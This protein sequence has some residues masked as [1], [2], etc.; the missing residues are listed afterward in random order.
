MLIFN[1]YQSAY[2]ANAVISLN[3][4]LGGD[5]TVKWAEIQQRE[6]GKHMIPKPDIEFMDNVPNGYV[7]EK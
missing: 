5:I 7:E 3:M 6:D 2:I 1:D 4:R